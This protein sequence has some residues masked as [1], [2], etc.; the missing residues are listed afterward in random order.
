MIFVQLP[1][2]NIVSVNFCGKCDKEQTSAEVIR[3]IDI[4]W[5]AS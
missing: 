3:R 5:K 4:D 2:Y 1:L